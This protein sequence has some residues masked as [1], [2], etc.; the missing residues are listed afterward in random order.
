MS[1]IVVLLALALFSL[2]ASATKEPV[3]WKKVEI[4]FS[5]KANKYEGVS[6][7]VSLKEHKSVHLD[8]TSESKEAVSAIMAAMKYENVL[9][10]CSLVLANEKITKYSYY[11]QLEVTCF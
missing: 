4:L 6:Y 1:R 10:G 8:V 11:A 2:Q 5:N 3:F 9:K 7:N